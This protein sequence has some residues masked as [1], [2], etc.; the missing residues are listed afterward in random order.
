MPSLNSTVW[1]PDSIARITVCTL[2]MQVTSLTELMGQN[3]TYG[4]PGISWGSM[5]R[6]RGQNTA[7]P[8]KLDFRRE[9]CNNLVSI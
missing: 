5:E 4:H 9:F 6:S 7:S 2:E 3:R 1:L 8:L